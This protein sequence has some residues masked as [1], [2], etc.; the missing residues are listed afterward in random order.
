MYNVVTETSEPFTGITLATPRDL[1]P[2]DKDPYYAS[3]IV[4]VWEPLIGIDEQ[5][6]IK[7]ILATAWEHNASYTEW[8]FHIRQNVKFHDGRDLNAKAVYANIMRWQKL[9][10]AT[11]PFYTF[12]FS[13]IYP[14]FSGVH[15]MDEYTIRLYFSK[16]QPLL[17]ERMIGFSSIIVSPG[18]FDASTAKYIMPVQG[19]GPFKLSGYQ[20]NRYVDLERFEGYYGEKAKSPRIRILVIPDAETRYAALKAEEIDGV[21]DLGALTP[22]LTKELFQDARF[23]ASQTLST[24]NQIIGINGTN[25]PLSEVAMRQS[26]QVLF[27]RQKIVD[28]YYGNFAKPESSFLN[29]LNPYAIL[30]PVIYDE[31][32]AIAL[33]KSVLGEQRIQG[34]LLVPQYG[35]NRYSYQEIASYLQY[36]LRK[37]QIDVQVVV[38]DGAA[39][40]K[41]LLDGDYLFYIGSQGLHNYNPESILIPYMSFKG[42]ANLQ[43]HLGYTDKNSDMLLQRLQQATDLQEK[44][45]IYALLQERAQIVPPVIT[46]THDYN[47]VIYNKYLHGYQALP[48]G[49]TLAKVWKENDN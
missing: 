19:T 6:K 39:Y 48:Y 31:D 18:C 17:I 9:S 5:G 7:G 28:N 10:R 20:K 34:T 16:P 15:V 13:S 24:I 43:Y 27:D 1:V 40:K 45:N 41:R 32:L 37:I 4:Q 26:L 14:D 42:V 36:Q 22:A 47:V 12:S 23:S 25:W 33:A 8:T 38:L 46:L 30:F 35:L 44:G 29:A 2:G 11:S 49:I 21:F 3:S